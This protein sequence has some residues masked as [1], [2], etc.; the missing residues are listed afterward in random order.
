MALVIRTT[1]FQDY[2]DEKARIRA[3]ILGPPGAGKTRSASFW[4]KPFLL[5]CEKGQMAVADRSLPYADIASQ[6]DMDDALRYLRLESM[7][8]ERRY[9]T[10][11]LDTLDN[12]QRRLIQDYLRRNNKSSMSGWQDWGYLDGAMQQ[13]VDQ[14]QNLDMNVVVN[15]HVKESMEGDEEDGTKQRIY[16]PKLKGDLRDQIAAEFDF[17]G[18]MSVD[19]AA[20]NGQRVLKRQVRWMPEPKY[21]FLKDR[22]G[23][24]GESTVIDFTEDDYGR[25]LNLLVGGMD[26]L[27]EGQEVETIES[28]AAEEAP[29]PVAAKPGGVVADPST[30]ALP[31]KT[32]QPKP[33]KAEA[34]PE[35]AAPAEAAPETPVAAAPVA[36][37][38]AAPRPTNVPA[39]AK[40]ATA[41]ASPVPP[42]EAT[43]TPVVAEPAAPEVTE[44]AVEAAAEGLGA[45]VV[46]DTGADDVVTHEE[47]AAEPAAAPAPAP[48]GPPVPKAFIDYSCGEQPPSKVGAYPPAP[49]CGTALRETGTT[50]DKLQITALKAHTLLCPGCFTVFKQSN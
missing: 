11:I 38:P 29:A 8:R 39:A 2:L 37:V 32:A 1:G 5:N 49:G 20:A 44:A 12:Y 21:P 13:L 18:F 9:D 30:V 6:Q 31:R 50:N 47:P 24:L 19:Y 48:S 7:K 27:P 45:T 26:Q 10:A 41:A 46:S 22:S 14:L 42:A 4:P 33:P 23:R 25:L 3:L 15:L 16:S 35:A 28:A 43:I 40:P 36:N 34:S 17:V